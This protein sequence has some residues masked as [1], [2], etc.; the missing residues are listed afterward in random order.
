MELAEV[1][2][3]HRVI[4]CLG[5]GGVGKTTT[6]AAIAVRAALAGRRTL[7]L[8]IDPAKR[9]ANSL[10]L[11]ELSDEEQRIDPAVFCEHGLECNGSL[12]AMM[13]DMKHTFDALVTRHATSEAQRNRILDNRIYQYVSTSLAGT[14]EY[15]AMEKLHAVH[16]DPRFDF[17]V[18]DTPPTT[19]ALDFLDAPQKLVGAIDSPVMRWFVEQLEGKRGIGLLGKGAAYVLRG[20]SRFTGAEF[21]DHVGQFVTDVNELFGGFRDRAQAVYD[22]LR[23]DDVGFLIVTSPSPLSVAEAVYFSKKLGDYGIDPQGVVV[24][25]VHRAGPAP[26]AD[27]RAALEARLSEAQD[28]AGL[29]QRVEQAAADARSL[30]ERDQEGVRRLRKHVGADMSYTEVP[31]L[32]QDVHDLSALA[33]VGE[34]LMGAMTEVSP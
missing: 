1:V 12:S 32:S 27:T 28:T 19:N 13:L 16:K 34:H 29:V 15:M 3:R 22:D 30:A 4:V 6:S 33:R 9:L 26:D 14:Q 10:G 23:S 20:L 24:N 18:L 7:C 2:D 11:S 8:T 21:L 31:A 5:S 17:I 25:R